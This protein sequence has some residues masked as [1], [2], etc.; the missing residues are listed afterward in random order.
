MAVV[1]GGAGRHVQAIVLEDA[2]ILIVRGKLLYALSWVSAWSNCFSRLSILVLFRRIFTLGIP[3]I[4]TILLIIYMILFILSQTVV[5]AV[6]CR[7]IAAFWDISIKGTC[8]NQFLF[9]KMSGILNIVGDVAIMALPVHSV[10]TLHASFARRA[11]IA[12]AF[13]SGSM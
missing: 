2:H 5:G 6:E 12:A 3:R 11:G 7:P 9:Y 8:I 13:L 10:W 1:Y 4:C